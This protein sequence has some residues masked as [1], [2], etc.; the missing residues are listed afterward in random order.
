MNPRTIAWHCN[1]NSASRI[2]T[3]LRKHDSL[4]LRNAFA[5]NG[6]AQ[7]NIFL[8]SNRVGYGIMHRTTEGLSFWYTKRWLKSHSS[9]AKPAY[10]QDLPLE[11]RGQPITTRNTTD[12]EC[13]LQSVGMIENG[14][15]SSKHHVVKK[16]HNGDV[17][18][19]KLHQR[20]LIS[21]SMVFYLHQDLSKMTSRSILLNGKGFL[22][23]SPESWEC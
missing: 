22:E 5:K 11:M 9:T 12:L 10:I 20:Q 23:R 16:W 7:A 3:H 14:A 13:L 19:L 4:C 8:W 15:T 18:E 6:V 1:W 21:L 2:H 17:W